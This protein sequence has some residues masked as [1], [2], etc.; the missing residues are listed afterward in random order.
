M[1]IKNEI[2]YLDYLRAIEKEN[3]PE[4]KSYFSGKF[5]DE[6]NILIV[7]RGR[8]GKNDYAPFDD[9]FDI[10]VSLYNS[11]GI[12]TH[13]ENTDLKINPDIFDGEEQVKNH[14]AENLYKY[15]KI[16]K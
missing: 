6:K 15:L 9:M 14:L 8:T 5:I 2:E 12:K 4:E 3:Y 10:S 13:I 1:N 7:V 11:E 16:I